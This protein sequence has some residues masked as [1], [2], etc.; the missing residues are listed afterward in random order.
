MAKKNKN[1]AHNPQPQQQKQTIAP[2]TQEKEEPQLPE[3]V[4]PTGETVLSTV[5]PVLSVY[6]QD[7]YF[8]VRKLTSKRSNSALLYERFGYKW[9]QEC[10]QPNCQVL[11]DKDNGK[12]VGVIPCIPVRLIWKK[13][14]DWAKGKPE[15]VY[16]LTQNEWD[17]ALRKFEA[18]FERKRHMSGG[19]KVNRP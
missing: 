14:S 15:S 3:L 8:G 17:A 16:S 19:E 7:H 12:K 4:E 18:Y 13:A 10:K 5:D 1:V 2:Q 9:G 6:E 11:L